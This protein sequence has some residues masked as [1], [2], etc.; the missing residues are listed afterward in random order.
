MSIRTDT[1]APAGFIALLEQAIRDAD[2]TCRELA[3]KAKISHPFLSRLLSGKRGLPADETISRLET[4]L[5]L[6]PGQLA[7]EAGRP[8]HA[9]KTVLKK[10]KA[11]LLMRTLAP[12][13]DKEL[14]QVQE[15]AAKLAKKYHKEQ[16]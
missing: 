7:Y 6:P 10:S 2:L 4:A 16:S 15:L 9:A 14:Q 11:P 3:E 12:L 8:D 1:P 5:D 13:N